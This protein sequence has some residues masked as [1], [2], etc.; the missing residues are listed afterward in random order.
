MTRTEV[1]GVRLT[2][3]ERRALEAAAARAGRSAS[4][5]ARIA[6]L[7]ASRAM[8]RLARTHVDVREVGR[9]PKEREPRTRRARGHELSRGGVL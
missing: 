2:P 3:A 7:A 4:A 5:L 8:R 9:G 1:F 6:I